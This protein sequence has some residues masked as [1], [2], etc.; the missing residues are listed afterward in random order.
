MMPSFQLVKPICWGCQFQSVL[1]RE[2]LA[3]VFKGTKRLEIWVA[4]EAYFELAKAFNTV[5]IDG[6]NRDQ[7][8]NTF[9]KKKITQSLIVRI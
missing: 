6:L 9:D 5:W 1:I 8:E 3:A 4:I 2:R 7:N